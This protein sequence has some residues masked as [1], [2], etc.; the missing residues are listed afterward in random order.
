MP[1]LVELLRSP[2]KEY[3]VLNAASGLGY[4]GAREAVPILLGLLSSSNTGVGERA[5]GSLQQ[6]THMRLDGDHSAVSPQPQSA[7]WIQWWTRSQGTAR[8]YKASECGEF[9]PLP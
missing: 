4:T 1:L 6:L 8:I 7:R 2:D 5:L 3:T 9:S